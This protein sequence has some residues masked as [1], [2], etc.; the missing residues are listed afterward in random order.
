MPYESTQP[1]GHCKRLHLMY[2]QRLIATTGLG[3]HNFKLQIEKQP[4]QSGTSAATT[5]LMK[6]CFR[7]VQSNR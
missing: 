4:A 3:Q 5:Q 7:L 1:L 6:S 2:T